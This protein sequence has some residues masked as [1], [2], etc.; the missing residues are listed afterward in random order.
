MTSDNL[1]FNRDADRLE[2]SGELDIEGLGDLVREVTAFAGTPLEFDLSGLTF[3]DS[4]G[5]AVLLQ[6]KRERP[7]TRIV[8]ASDSM[9]ALFRSLGVEAL[10][11]DDAC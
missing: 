3:V 6:V 8:G 4:S 1:R 7:N 2:L 11:L 5:I 9:R 10:L